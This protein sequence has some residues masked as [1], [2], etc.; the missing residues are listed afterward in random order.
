M[1]EYTW[2]KKAFDEPTTGTSSNEKRVLFAYQHIIN[3]KV[4][5]NAEDNANKIGRIRNGGETQLLVVATIVV[6]C[7]RP[8][9]RA[10][11]V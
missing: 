1:D 10:S 6:F 5:Q 8:N 7:C 2:E 9:M 4:R 3:I 11:H